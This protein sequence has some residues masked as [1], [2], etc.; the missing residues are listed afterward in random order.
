[1]P[2]TAAAHRHLGTNERTIDTTVIVEDG[3]I[4]VLGGLIEDVLRESTQRVPILGSIPLIGAL[5]RTRSVDKVKTNLIVFIRPKMRVRAALPR[6]RHRWKG[7]Y[8][9]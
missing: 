2:C 3:Q 6:S 1:M 4:L 9:E 7:R 8:G 5:F